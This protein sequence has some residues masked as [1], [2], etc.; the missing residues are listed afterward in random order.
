M[1]L[2]LLSNGKTSG[3]AELLGYA[4][5]QIMAVIER[6]K[7]AKAILIPYALIRSDYDDRA[8]DSKKPRHF[9]HQHSPL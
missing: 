2:I 1:E 6:Q 7:V 8:R 4:K 5:Q 9:R 3:D